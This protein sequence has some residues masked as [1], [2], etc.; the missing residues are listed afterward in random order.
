MLGHSEDHDRRGDARKFV[1]RLE[2][3]RELFR[4]AR[5]LLDEVASTFRSIRKAFI[6]A[7]ILVEV[8]K[9]LLVLGFRV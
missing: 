4:A 8:I 5:E 6:S 1:E 9:F 7:W 3:D 2:Q